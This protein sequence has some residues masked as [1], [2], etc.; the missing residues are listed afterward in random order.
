M[1]KMTFGLNVLKDQIFSPR[2]KKH[3]W[4]IK[5]LQFCDL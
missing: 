1:Q 3:A 2:A 4:C 5:S